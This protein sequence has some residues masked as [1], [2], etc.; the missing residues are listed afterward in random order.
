VKNILCLV[1]AAVVASYFLAGCV[2]QSSNPGLSQDIS[3]GRKNVNSSAAEGNMRFAFDIF[4]KLYKHKIKLKNS[5]C[6]F[7]KCNRRK[8]K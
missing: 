3:S 7:G 6:K 5:R 4:R 1:M 8:E 2:S